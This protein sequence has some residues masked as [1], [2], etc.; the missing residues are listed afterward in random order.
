MTEKTDKN[1]L[2]VVGDFE[3]ALDFDQL[4]KILRSKRVIIGSSGK[5][6]P[7]RN[8]INQIARIRE[9]L[10]DSRIEKEIGKLTPERIGIF[11]AENES[12]KELILSITRK[13]GLRTKVIELTIKEIT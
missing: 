10:E 5:K 4:Y 9:K 7:A 3:K 8:I 1:E 6:Y 2:R 12:L 11:M 13:E